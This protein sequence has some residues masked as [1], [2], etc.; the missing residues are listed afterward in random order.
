MGTATW[1][2][3]GFRE[4]TRV[5]GERPIDISASFGQHLVALLFPSNVPWKVAGKREGKECR[6]LKEMEEMGRACGLSGL[7]WDG[8]WCVMVGGQSWGRRVLRWMGLGGKSSRSVRLFGTVPA[9]M[10]HMQHRVFSGC[11]LQIIV[12][13]GF[14]M[15]MIGA[16]FEILDFA[17]V[18]SLVLTIIVMLTRVLISTIGLLGAVYRSRPL[19]V[20]CAVTRPPLQ[21]GFSGAVCGGDFV[22]REGAPRTHRELLGIV[23][24]RIGGNGGSSRI[25]R[26]AQALSSFKLPSRHQRPQHAAAA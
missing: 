6:K 1:G 19:L 26:S 14:V 10:S 3:T 5:S 13:I 24:S 11:S 4:R 9:T 23:V 20:V 2:G 17:E 8:S 25:G 7:E 16:V 22:G 15:D 18:E 12:C 21:R